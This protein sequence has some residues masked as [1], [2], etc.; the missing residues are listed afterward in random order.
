[1]RSLVSDVPQRLLFASLISMGILSTSALAQQAP[2]SG[3]T[4]SQPFITSGTGQEQGVTQV[5]PGTPTCSGASAEC[6]KAITENTYAALQAVNTLPVYLYNAGQYILNWTAADKSSSTS[7][8]Q[9]Y[10]TGIGNAITNNNAYV[11]D[12]NNLAQIM[13]DTLG[14]PSLPVSVQDFNEPQ[15]NPKIKTILGGL[16]VNDFAFGTILGVPPVTKGDPAN[17]YSYLQNASGM[18]VKHTI[19]SPA[20]QGKKQDRD[21]YT[22]YYKMLMSIISYDSYILDSLVADSTAGQNGFTPQQASLIQTAANGNF[23][24]TVATEEL[25]PVLRQILMFQSQAYLMLTQLVVLQKQQ[26]AT[27]AMTNSLLITNNSLN[28]SLMVSKAMGVPLT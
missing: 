26:M 19:P 11:N 15:G 24:A 21:T 6:L 1:M 2:T 9:G 12:A 28:E 27:Q 16:N 3:T 20:W 22:N 13:A 18:N 17:P 4:S 25:G 5:P 23:L 14:Q 7:T 10:F 8:M